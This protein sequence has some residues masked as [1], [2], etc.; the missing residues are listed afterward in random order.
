MNYRYGNP[1]SEEERAA[2]HEDLYPGTPLPERG[3]GRTRMSSQ[4]GSSRRRVWWEE[5]AAGTVISGRRRIEQS[6]GAGTAVGIIGAALI[7]GLGVII[8]TRKT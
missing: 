1:R 3:T 2:R 4:F 5:E 6:P 7:L 8:A